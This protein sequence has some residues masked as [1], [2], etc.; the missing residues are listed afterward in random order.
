[1]IT[2]Y[3]PKFFKDLIKIIFFYNSY[4]LIRKNKSDAIKLIKKLKFNNL[5]HELI[6][7]G[8][9]DDGGYLLPNILKNVDYCF[10]P[11]VGKTSDFEREL[12]KIGINSFLIDGTLNNEL[13]FKKNEFDFEP[14]NLGVIDTKYEITLETWIKNKN[15]DKNNNL[16]L[17]IDIEGH[18]IPCILN[19]SKKTLE[20]FKIIIL[21]L[22]F[23]DELT[24]SGLICLNSLFDK[25]NEIFDIC[26]IHPNNCCGVTNVSGVKVPNVMEITFLRKD[27]T[28]D[29]KKINELPNPLDQ[30]CVEYNQD[31]LLDKFFIE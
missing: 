31:I 1:V 4:L 5:G 10:S 24:N 17:Q 6:R 29:K 28:L 3:I 7:V 18:E 13:P 2:K 27:L 26:H 19:A 30:K 11:G 16:L 20:Q 23:M 22:H 15:L 25:L 9:K 14:F 8:S 12:K 21:E